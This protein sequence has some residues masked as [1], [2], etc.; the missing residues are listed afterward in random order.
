[1]EASEPTLKRRRRAKN[2]CTR[3]ARLPVLA[4]QGSASVTVFVLVTLLCRT[5]ARN[6]R[7]SGR[8]S[9]TETVPR[10]DQA[11][12]PDEIHDDKMLLYKNIHHPSLFLD[13][14]CTLCIT[15][16]MVSFTRRHRRRRELFVDRAFHPS[17]R[18][19]APSKIGSC[20][21]MWRKEVE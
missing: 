10:P 8:Q 16:I 12:Q 5:A 9:Q 17:Q 19:P 6:L 15:C 3:R 20:L 18:L 2:I 11:R 14:T 21:D 7:A 13:L 4:V 1:M